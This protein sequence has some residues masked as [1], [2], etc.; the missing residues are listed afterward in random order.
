M[1]DNNSALMFTDVVKTEPQE[2][3]SAKLPDFDLLEDSYDGALVI[4]ED[5]DINTLTKEEKVKLRV[6]QRLLNAER[7]LMPNATDIDLAEQS[8]VNAELDRRISDMI[9]RQDGGWVCTVCGKQANHKSKL[10]QHAET[11]LQGYS[12]P[13]IMCGKTYR[14]RY[15][16]TRVNNFIILMLD[17]RSQ[18]SLIISEYR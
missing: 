10:K 3:E 9:V 18:A 7:R 11:H 8:E 12:H 16:I 2:E 17:K 6:Q 5:E 13:C 14:S 1:K 15:K 4:A